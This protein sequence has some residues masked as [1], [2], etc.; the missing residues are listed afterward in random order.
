MGYFR[1]PEIKKEG[2]IWLFA[3]LLTAVLGWYFPPDSNAAHGNKF[4]CFAFA[5]R[6]A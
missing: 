5:G 3:V 4:N 6:K 2:I 1:N